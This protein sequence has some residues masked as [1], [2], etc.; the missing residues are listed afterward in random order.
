MSDI[1]LNPDGKKSLKY[2]H[3]YRISDISECWSRDSIYL[4]STVLVLDIEY[5][6]TSVQSRI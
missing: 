3:L 5:T 2:Y 6:E 1:F 4:R